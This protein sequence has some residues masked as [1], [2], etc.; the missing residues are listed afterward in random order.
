T[1]KT[2]VRIPLAL[3]M[4][5]PYQKH[6]IQQV[7]NASAMHALELHPPQSGD[8]VRLHNL[9]GGARAL[10]IARLQQ[11]TDCPV[12]IV[13]ADAEAA[14]GW[15]DDLHQVS[16]PGLHFFPM[17]ETLPYEIDEP[18]IDL[19]AK[20]YGAMHYLRR[21]ED[22]AIT[23]AP[24]AREEATPAAPVLLVAPLEALQHKIPTP[25]ALDKLVLTLNWGE[26]FDTEKIAHRL[27]ELGYE[28][29]AMAETRGEFS[30]RGNI[31]DI[32]PPHFENPVRFDLFGDEVESIRFFDS[33]TQRS[34]RGG[35]ELERI[36]ILPAKLISITKNL[37]EESVDALCSLADWM[38]ENTLVVLDQPEKF[39]EAL[40]RFDL[41]AQKRY[42]ERDAAE[43]LRP[44][45]YYADKVTLHQ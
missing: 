5:S 28:R 8:F 25:V 12:L 3:P 14:E 27:V 6:L 20:Q 36:T 1:A 31:V 38:P 19:L 11:I 18:V 7:A 37:A 44:A 10:V 35:P 16:P 17:T 33:T 32:F 2:G 45:V 4:P 15:Y 22:A 26:T 42:E 34:L 24:K 39:D 21:G 13:T 40:E 30:V 43:T 9:S 29:Q 41:I 23:A